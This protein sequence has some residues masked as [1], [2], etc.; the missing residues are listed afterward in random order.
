MKFSEKMWFIIILNVTKKQG[1]NF[2]LENTFFKSNTSNKPDKL[3]E[4]P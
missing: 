2:Y 3:F 1:F 4:V